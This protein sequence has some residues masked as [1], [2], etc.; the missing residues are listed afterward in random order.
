[1]CVLVVCVSGMCVY[2]C[3]DMYVCVVCKCVC[4]WWVYVC[5]CEWCVVPM[6]VCGRC[7]CDWCM[8]VSGVCVCVCESNV[9]CKNYLCVS[10]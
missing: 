10:V 1:M 3:G 6:R 9:L 4:I 2:V 7:L 8:Y 5:V